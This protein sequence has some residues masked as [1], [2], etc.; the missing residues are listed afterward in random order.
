MSD[1]SGLFVTVGVYL[2]F[3][4]AVAV[5]SYVRGKQAVKGGNEDAQV[6]E[7]FLA[8]S[9]F[10]TAVLFLTTFSTI[11]SGYTA[12]N[13][14]SEVAGIGFI[15]F[16]WIQGFVMITMGYVL[17]APRYRRIAT[18]RNWQSP[19]DIIADKYNCNSLRLLSAFVQ[20]F[21][22]L[23]YIAVQFISL[24]RMID[25]LSAGQISGEAGVWFL[26][27]FIWICEFIGGFRGVSL[28]DAIQS[29]F[30]LV[31]FLGIPILLAVEYGGFIGI[32]EFPSCVNAVLT[33]AGPIGCLGF[34]NFFFNFYPPRAQSDV[35]QGSWGV[36]N[37]GF[38]VPGLTACKG[39][40]AGVEAGLIPSNNTQYPVCLRAVGAA[41]AVD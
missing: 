29:G 30:M 27:A 3:L 38:S 33:P 18:A 34:T 12:F 16:R 17:L 37:P 8:S 19:N 24:E 9:S 5:F 1:R 10:G 25:Q 23:L 28:T 14:P 6:N 21:P 2:A 32:N 35:L 20:C 11:V 13:I 7:H 26:V 39:L 36:F 4:L 41:V 40:I 15:A 22:L 31:A